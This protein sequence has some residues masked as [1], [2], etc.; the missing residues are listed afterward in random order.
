MNNTTAVAAIV[1]FAAAL[2]TAEPIADQSGDSLPDP[3]A[4]GWEGKPVCEKLHE[5]V[6]QRVLRCTFPPG[7]GHERHF[8]KAHFGYVLTGGRMRINDANGEREV[9]LAANYTWNN[10]GV[11]WHEVL[12]IGETTAIYLIV[13]PL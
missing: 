2:V 1:L 3:L 6:R 5:N 7:V 13:E 8:H 9:E 12:N 4:A 10:A 11:A